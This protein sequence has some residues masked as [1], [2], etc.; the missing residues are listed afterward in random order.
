MSLSHAAREAV[1]SG[2]ELKLCSK[3]GFHYPA[4]TEFFY[5]CN[6]APGGLRYHCKE[7][8]KR[9]ARDYLRAKRAGT[10]PPPKKILPGDPRECGWCHVTLP[11]TEEFYAIHSRKPD[12]S[13]ARLDYYCRECRRKSARRHYWENVEQSRARERE[14]R[15]A[16]KERDPERYARLQRRHTERWRAKRARER[17]TDPLLPSAPVLPLLETFFG[18]TEGLARE[19]AKRDGTRS[20]AT[21]SRQIRRWKNGAALRESV[22]DLLI[23][24]AFPD[25]ELADFWP[26]RYEEEQVPYAARMRKPSVRRKTA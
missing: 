23:V 21:W 9:I 15:R 7:C 13:I 4:T 12:G 2:A 26:D 1:E 25:K 24:I 22:A 5:R 17:K 8:T 18:G 6:T 19:M 3:C 16:R 11:W 20:A 10:L 14:T